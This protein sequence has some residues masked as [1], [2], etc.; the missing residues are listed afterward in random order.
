MGGCKTKGESP[1]VKEKWRGE[2]SEKGYWGK[3]SDIGM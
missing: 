3:G 1:L 2:W